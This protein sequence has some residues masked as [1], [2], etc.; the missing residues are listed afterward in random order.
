MSIYG[1]LAAFNQGQWVELFELDLLP[2]GGDLLRFHAGTNE[3]A[4]PIV[5]AGNEYAP[6]PVE[7]T[8]FA[9][10]STGAVSRPSF[11]V[12][13]V[14]GTITQVL[15]VTGGIEG[16]R[17][18]RKRTQVRYLDAVNFV[19]GNPSADSLSALPDDVFYVS[20]KKVET[21]DVVEF[22]LAPSTDLQGVM[23]PRRQ[24]NANY[25]SFEYRGEE[26]GYAGGACAKIDDTP[27]NDMLLD[28]C[29]KQISGCKL[30]FGANGA[31]SF[32]GFP[33]AGL[34]RFT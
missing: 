8:G 20:Q 1:N 31:L 19:G 26:C 25:C 29:S 23:L 33:A 18:T 9:K 27:T 12:A 4:Q 14:T 32:G 6:F 22:E 16:A 3:F 2:F 34:V 5:W 28:R 24:I 15:M 30:R 13:N 11:K 17:F 21:P 10:S 7:V